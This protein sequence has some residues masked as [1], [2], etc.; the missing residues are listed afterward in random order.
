MYYFSY[1]YIYMYCL[2]NNSMHFAYQVYTLYQTYYNIYN[3]YN[4]LPRCIIYEYVPFTVAL[5]SMRWLW[6]SNNVPKSL[7]PHPVSKYTFHNYDLYS[8]LPHSYLFFTNDMCIMHVHM[9]IYMYMTGRLIEML[10]LKA[11]TLTNCSLLVL[12]EADRMWVNPP[13]K[14]DYSLYY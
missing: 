1:N 2:W 9:F 8:T 10:R 14:Y 4:Y 3:I 5:A 11:T 12:D 13:H 6:L 7:L